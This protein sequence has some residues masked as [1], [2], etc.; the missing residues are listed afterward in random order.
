MSD[1][2]TAANLETRFEAGE[3][4]SDYFD[5]ERA[6]RINH[7]KQRLNLDLPRWMIERLDLTASR[8]GVPRQAQIKLWLA[9]RLKG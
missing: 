8:N 7:R 5:F 2:T 4:V 6:E 1:K 3:D 9:E